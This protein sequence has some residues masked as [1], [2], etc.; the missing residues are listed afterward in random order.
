MNIKVN[1]EISNFVNSFYNNFDDDD[2]IYYTNKV[3]QIVP[4]KNSIKINSFDFFDTVF[5]DIIISNI[6]LSQNSTEMTRKEVL[7]VINLIS[8][9][10]D[11]LSFKV[12][13]QKTDYK[14][15]SIEFHLRGNYNTTFLKELESFL[16]YDFELIDEEERLIIT[17]F[18]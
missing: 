8:N 6:S 12:E 1:T 2:C 13:Y 16:T 3:V 18:K 9:Y 14:V 11:L 17:K 10:N 4:F 5:T 15:F 7:R